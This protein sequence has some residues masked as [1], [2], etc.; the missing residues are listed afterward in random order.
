MSELENDLQL[1]NWLSIASFDLHKYVKAGGQ[2]EIMADEGGLLVRFVGVTA[3]DARLH[4]KFLQ[5][6][7]DTPSVS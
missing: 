1:A 7:E 6:I 3:D 2:I 4:R 5:M